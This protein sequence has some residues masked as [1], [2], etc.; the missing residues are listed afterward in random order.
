MIETGDMA[1]RLRALAALT[2]GPCSLLS[3]HMVAQSQLLFQG[4]WC[5]ILTSWGIKCAPGTQMYM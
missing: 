1:H 4:I 5:H 3:T 2:E